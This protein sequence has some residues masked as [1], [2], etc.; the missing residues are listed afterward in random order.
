MLQFDA[1]QLGSAI[2]KLQHDNFCGVAYVET[3]SSA[4]KLQHPRA[5]S[6]LNGEL[7]YAGLYLPAPYEL[8]QN[9]DST[10]N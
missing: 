6:F 3:H 9:W 5:L 7:T 2:L 4:L 10:L 8:S 1:E